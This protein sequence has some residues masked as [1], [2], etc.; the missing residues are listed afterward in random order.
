[1]NAFKFISWC[2][3]RHLGYGAAKVIAAIMR[4]KDEEET[5][6]YWLIADL[7]DLCL[8]NIRYVAN[9]LENR[10]IAILSKGSMR[11]TDEVVQQLQALS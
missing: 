11:L 2:Q 10:G 5:I 9:D 6:Y 3:E 1:M 7:T 8:R 4:I